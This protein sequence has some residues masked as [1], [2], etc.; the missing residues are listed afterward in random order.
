MKIG[1]IVG[2]HC[3]N[4]RSKQ[5]AHWFQNRL[6]P[7]IAE[8]EIF[9]LAELDMPFWNENFWSP[10]SPESNWWTPISERLKS[11]EAM[12]IVAPEWAGMMPP[13]LGNFFLLC[14][15]K[16]LSYKPTLL[17]SVS[18][19]KGGTYPIAQL[20]MSASKN[21]QM[22]YLPDHLIL[23][24]ADQFFNPKAGQ[25]ESSFSNLECHINKRLDFNIKILCEM[26]LALKTVREQNNL[27]LFAYGM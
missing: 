22:I 24:D 26:A 19:G 14:G 6:P 5:A 8:A 7:G 25:E 20:R 27:N 10:D 1:L 11:C 13:K 23:R 15:A 16:E 17:M 21:N 3:K 2:S 18:S 12:V 4:S 9:D